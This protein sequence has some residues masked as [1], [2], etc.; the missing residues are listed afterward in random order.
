M[1]KYINIFLGLVLIVLAFWLVNT[2]I[3]S[4]QRK[5]RPPKKIVKTVFVEEVVN[6]NI[7]I[8][9]K[10]NGN[11][12]AKNKI[13]I[14]SEVQGIL[15]NST[16]EFKPG[17][18]Y[19]KG[20]VIL[21]INNEEHLANLQAQKSNLYNSITS[22]MP[23]IRLDY[24]EAYDKWEEYL[25]N[26]DFDKT[27]PVL[28]ETESEKEKFF[29]S[30]R[31]IYTTYYNVKNMEVRLSKYTI[32]APF[33]GI[34]TEALVNRGSLIRQGQKLGEFINP[35]L[36]EME[37]AINAKYM[38]LLQKGNKVEVLNRDN[39]QSWEAK[40]VRV[41]GKVDQSSQTVKAYIEVKGDGLK[42]GMYLEAHLVAKA[43]ENAYRIA[44]KLLVN[45]QSVY[46]LKDSVLDLIDVN[47]VY[48]DEKTV[49]V[50]GL[51]NGTTILNRTVPGAHVGMKVQ[52]H[53]SNQAQN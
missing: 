18:S 41:N 26:F 36:Y 9:I 6:K 4:N 2:M 50:K 38:D 17:N 7:P 48:F 32:R 23:D 35:N 22:I 24:P 14:Y 5:Q 13:Q 39:N 46:V 20:E 16:K 40:I 42:E 47:P 34:L 10:A 1:R 28:P 8:T 31:N 51:E 53:E 45:N 33:H 15:Q 27:T 19:A 52:V 25:R 44:R 12:E 3:L 30:G 37:V 29:I 21:R 49:V 43:E 11:L